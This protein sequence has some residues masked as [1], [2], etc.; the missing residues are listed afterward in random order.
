MDAVRPQLQLHGHWHLPYDKTLTR[1][2]G[3]SV[4]IVSLN[5][6]AAAAF[7]ANRHC[8]VL[9]LSLLELDVRRAV[10]VID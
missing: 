4:R 9:D 7:E 6:N 8:A 5:C 2:D 10:T 3:S 1:P